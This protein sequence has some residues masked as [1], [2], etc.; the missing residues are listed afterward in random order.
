[1]KFK[2]TGISGTLSLAILYLRVYGSWQDDVHTT[3]PSGTPLPNPGLGDCLVYH[4]NDYA[5]IDFA[6]FNLYTASIGNDPGVLISGTTTPIVGYVGV[7][8]KAA[9][10][11]DINKGR[12]YTTFT[13]K[14]AT[15]TDSDT[16]N[17][18]WYFDDPMIEYKLVTPTP[19]PVGGVLAP[20]NKLAMLTPYLALAGLI[21]VLFTVTVVRKR[22]NA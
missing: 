18:A 4:I 22:R 11:D 7:D 15:D 9:M 8:V 1:V 14:L 13:I 16:W 2:L 3:G 20:V 10:Q 12:S 17:D 6:D 5:P 19:R 21:A